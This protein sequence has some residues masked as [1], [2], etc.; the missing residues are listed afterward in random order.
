MIDR[1]SFELKWLLSQI[2]QLY[3]LDTYLGII[4]ESPTSTLFRL[5]QRIL[6][7][8]F[9]SCRNPWRMLYREH[10]S[11]TTVCFQRALHFQ[12]NWLPVLIL[13]TT[14]FIISWPCDIIDRPLLFINFKSSEAYFAHRAGPN[15]RRPTLS[16]K[17]RL[18]WNM[19]VHFRAPSLFPTGRPLWSLDTLSRYQW[20]KRNIRSLLNRNSSPPFYLL[21]DIWVTRGCHVD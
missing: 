21:A 18:V 5:R 8:K 10:C 3:S 9:Y 4:C 12:S 2:R 14:G 16:L 17:I 15:R 6:K 7:Q 11:W 1:Y 19:T 20:P 13:W